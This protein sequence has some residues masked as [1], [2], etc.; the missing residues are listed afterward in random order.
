MPIAYNLKSLKDRRKE[1]RNNSTS[2]EVALWVKLKNGQTGLKWRRQ[3]SI[4][5]YV[6]DFYCPKK[7]LVVEIDGMHHLQKENKEY[8]EHRTEAFELL[9]L[10]VL[11]FTNEEINHNMSNILR[12]IEAT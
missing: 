5:G 9:G 12:L 10:K 3:H 7:K 1:L 2:Y 8:D 11:R 4:G 6:A